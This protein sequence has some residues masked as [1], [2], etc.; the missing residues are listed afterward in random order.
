[1]AEN[2]NQTLPNP[3][4]RAKRERES[5]IA[6]MKASKELLSDFEESVRSRN[7]TTP[8]QKARVLEDVRKAE[9]ENIQAARESGVTQ[10]QIDSAVYK[11]PTEEQKKKYAEHLKK[12]NTT[13]A[14]LRSRKIDEATVTAGATT[15]DGK[16][17]RRLRITKQEDFKVLQ[18]D[19]ARE[20][21]LMRMSLVTDDSQI[22]EQR[23]RNAVF[24]KKRAEDL[25][26]K[27]DE[28]EQMD[29]IAGK[30]AKPVVAG[31]SKQLTIDVEPKEINE[32]ATVTRTVGDII[33]EEM[34]KDAVS[35][36]SET[37][38]PKKKKPSKPLE[39]SFDFSTVPDY[40]QYD[41]IPLPSH[42][43]C[44]P[45]TSPLRCGRIP[46]AYLTA[47]D[48]NLIASPNMY[49]DGKIIDIIL[50]RKVLDKRINPSEL[51]RGDRDAITMWLRATGY[52]NDFPIVVTDPNDTSKRY[53]TSVDLST[54]DYLKF[55]L[56][57]D[58]EGYFDY[59]LERQNGRKD[60]IKFKVLTFQ[61]QEE[62][63]EIS[64][65]GLRESERARVKR[66]MDEVRSVI[67]G[68][69]DVD[70]TMRE[71]LGEDIDEISVWADSGISADESAE[72]YSKI[73]TENM[74]FCT[75]SVNGN[76]DK[77]Y[78]R[79]YVENMRSIDSYKYRSFLSE[80]VPGVDFNI[81]VNIPESEGG[82][83]FRSFLRIDDVVFANV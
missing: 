80:N 53:N 17:G 19:R 47:A 26:K 9:A 83:S 66:L 16:K 62:L 59:V 25:A 49:R 56:A 76:A 23:K 8:D 33:R 1:M 61:E 3:Q 2:T 73:I 32:E 15:G 50:A 21:E 27:M 63:R 35:N 79:G 14:R 6:I 18:L 51:C 12:K 39:Y 52:G 28:K 48:E 71:N 44:Y 69:D 45:V 5:Q 68:L 74:I 72:E 4:E 37:K 13:D 67:R 41:V 65:G 31:E 42:G 82:G 70:P 57:G 81:T 24:E 43:Q 64:T 22:E 10:E 29:R 60:N 11:Q 34:E 78:I 77:G 54:L 75:V 58:D 36:A 55:D 7:T 38:K 20:E 30:S 40:V 46:V